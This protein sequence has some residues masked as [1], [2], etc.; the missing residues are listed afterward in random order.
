MTTS[1]TKKFF[2]TAAVGGTLLAGSLG[3]SWILPSAVANAAPATASPATVKQALAKHPA[4]RHFGRVEF[5]VAAKTIGVKPTDL[6]ADL[7]SGQS[8]AE[9]A[10]SKG[11]P[12]DS[13][14]NAIVTDSTA[15]INDAVSHG[16]LSQTRAT[17]I[18]GELPQ[19]VTTLV[20]AHL[21]S[22]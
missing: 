13:V 10:N 1:K 21:G 17:K 19:W 4:L 2:A 8:I 6:R 18:E 11:V 16:H 3:A 22:L 7:K 9:V 12:V 20:N 5:R 15:K 14:V